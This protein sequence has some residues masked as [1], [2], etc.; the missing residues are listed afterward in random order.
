MYYCSVINLPFWKQLYTF[1]EIRFNPPP[2][3]FTPKAPQLLKKREQESGK[4]VNED[5]NR[6]VGGA[7]WGGGSGKKGTCQYNQAA[8]KRPSFVNY[9]LW[10]AEERRNSRYKFHPL[11]VPF[12][13]ALFFFSPHFLPPPKVVWQL[14]NLGDKLKAIKFDTKLRY[15]GYNVLPLLSA[16]S[17]STPWGRYIY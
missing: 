8:W 7:L 1:I 11:S 12:V 16:L 6:W 15:A 9:H 14:E 10:V 2:P 3:P 5:N 4:M 17:L 13:V